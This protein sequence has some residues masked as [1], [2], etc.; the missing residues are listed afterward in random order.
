[1]PMVNCLDRF[2]DT[3]TRNKTAIIWEADSGTYK[4]LTYHS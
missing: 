4:T 1:M 2:I 3:P